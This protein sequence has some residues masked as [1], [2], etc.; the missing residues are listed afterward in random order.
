MEHEDIINEITAILGDAEDI[1]GN[2]EQPET[3]EPQ[4]GLSNDGA[5]IIPTQDYRPQCTRKTVPAIG[6][7]HCRPIRSTESGETCG[8][9]DPAAAATETSIAAT[10]TPTDAG[11]SQGYGLH[12]PGLCQLR[13]RA[14]NRS[15]HPVLLGPQ[16]PRV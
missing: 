4:L 16:F 11:A 13:T 10:E 7:P 3:D 5:K 6:C 15:G 2:F 12:H 1:T 8:L 14:G 9:D